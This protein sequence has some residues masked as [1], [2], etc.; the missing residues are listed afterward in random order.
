MM[1]ALNYMIKH[2]IE[3]ENNY[4]QPNTREFECK[5]SQKMYFYH[6]SMIYVKKTQKRE[7]ETPFFV[8]SYLKLIGNLR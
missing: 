2:Q 8:I 4:I 3:I 5:M 1:S 7:V 6:F